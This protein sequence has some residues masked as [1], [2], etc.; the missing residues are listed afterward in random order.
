MKEGWKTSTLQ[1]V[2][3]IITDGTH[4]TPKYFDK[5]YIF[6]SSKNVTS[7]KIDW[8]NIKYIDEEQHQKMYSRLRP[9]IGD[10]LLAKNGTTGVAAIVD[11]NEVFDIYVSLA[12]LRPKE[13]ILPEFLLYFINSSIAKK[14]FN[15]RLKGIG[16]PNLH[17][18]EIRAVSFCFPPLPEQKR[19]VSILDEAF[20]GIEKAIANTEKNL[21][22]AQELFES[23]LRALY[24]N[25]ESTW[26]QTSIGNVCQQRKWVVPFQNRCGW[27]TGINYALY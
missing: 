8:D 24:S 7:W 4:Q 23:E 2:C 15:K 18:E 21:K 26:I 27:C 20:A 3:A 17:L 22:N 25:R 14:Q 11:K 9:R 12:L 6:L 10:I 1:A 19:I 16:V 5:G 13:F